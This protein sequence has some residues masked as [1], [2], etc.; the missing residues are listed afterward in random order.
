MRQFETLYKKSA[1]GQIN[2][3][4]MELDE[5]GKHRTV[6]GVMGGA[7]NVAGWTQAQPKNAGRS[8]AT[9]PD[10]QAVM[11]IEAEY[12]KKLEMGGYHKDIKD[13]GKS[14]YFMPM[15]AEKYR[16]RP[17]TPTASNPVWAQPK[18]N[19]IRCIITSEG[20]FSRKGKPIISAPHIFEQLIPFFGTW[21]DDW[22]LDGEI[23][24]HEFGNQLNEILSLAK[25]SKPTA[26]DLKASADKL[27]FWIYDFPSVDE[28]FGIRWQQGQDAMMEFQAKH[29]ASCLRL[30]PTYLINTQ[31]TLDSFFQGWLQAGFEG[32]MVRLEA[33]YENR[34]SRSLLKRKEF[35][36]E[37]FKL[38][39]VKDGKGSLSG[40]A[41]SVEID[42][43]DGRTSEASVAG[44]HEFR[45]WVYEHRDEL[46][47]TAVTVRYHYRTPD[48]IPY[49]PVVI[50]FHATKDREL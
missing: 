44:T 42:L 29:D 23:Y 39:G 40:V 37:E 3:W 17:V 33:E 24:S 28:K 10:Q 50:V 25:K 20:M 27:Q 48:G 47:D 18:L 11:E 1:N 43:G 8:N 41:C 32:Q 30:C 46:A 5:G 14:V 16:D 6:H 45:K 22:V 15:L 2:V 38:R 35:I 4:R 7:E 13:V 26:A 49:V 36:D 12:R 21:G 31:G 34:R 19:G 9:T